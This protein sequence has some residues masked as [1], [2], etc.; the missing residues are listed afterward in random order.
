MIMMGFKSPPLSIMMTPSRGMGEKAKGS[1]EYKH[2]KPQ[3][4]LAFLKN[5]STAKQQPLTL[6]LIHPITLKGSGKCLES[7]ASQG[8]VFSNC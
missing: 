5:S 4:T 1:T 6:L 7:K 3:I 2:L 8:D